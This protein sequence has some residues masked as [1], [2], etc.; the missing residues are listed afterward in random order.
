VSKLSITC[1]DWRP[2][3]RNTLVGF[4]RVEITELRLVIHDV[5]IHAKGDSR[6]AALPSRPWVRDGRVVTGED[7]KAQ[8][9]P[10]LEFTDRATREAFSRRVIEAIFACFPQAF[11]VEAMA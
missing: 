1:L 3:R 9:S 2:L 8:Y 7:G 10:I 6:W 4:A 5:G 11:A